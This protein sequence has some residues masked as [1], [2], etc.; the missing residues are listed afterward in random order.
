MRNHAA[1]LCGLMAVLVSISSID[2]GEIG[3]VEDFALAGDRGKALAQLVPGT[4]EYY[5]FHCLH[6]QN[7]GRLQE[8]EK[9]LPAWIK[10]HGHTARVREIKNRQALLQYQ[11]DPQKS[12]DYI[13]RQLGINFNHAKSRLGV[14]PTHPTRLNPAIIDYTTLQSQALS[15]YRENLRGI[16]SEGLYRLYGIRLSPYQLR[17]LL[18]RLQRPDFPGLVKLI[19]RDMG[20]RHSR[21]FGSLPIHRSLTMAQLRKLLRIKGNLRFNQN[22]INTYISRLQP[23]AYVDWQHDAK[24]RAEYLQKLWEFVNRLPATQNS[25]KAHVLYR[26]LVHER[27][28]GVFDQQLFLTYIKLPR[29]LSYVNPK[30][31]RS[32]EMRRHLVR[33]NTD[34]RRLT[35]LPPI[36]NDE[37][38]VRS[39]L[40]HFFLT[41]D[42]ISPYA[43]YIRETYLKRILAETRV[44]A[45]DKDVER[46]VS[47][48]TPRYFKQLKERVDIDFAPT[49]KTY[50][51]AGDPVRIKVDIKNVSKLIVKVYAINT[52]NFYKQSRSGNIDEINLDGLVANQ[53]QVYTYKVPP[54]RRVRRT[55]DFPALKK[56]GLYFVDFIGNGRSNRVVIR[57]G[58]LSFIERM[59]TAGQVLTILN[60]ANQPLPGARAWLAGH[61]YTADAEARVVIPFS[62]KPGTRT[63]VL[64]NDGFACRETFSHKAEKYR[65]QAGIHVDRESLLARKH[66]RVLIR[67][68]LQL[69]DIPV[70]LSVLREISLLISTR[71]HEG[72]V[73]SRKITGFKLYED[74]ESVHEF[75]VPGNLAEISFTLSAKIKPLSK[76]D[77]IDLSVKRTYR[78]NRID[79]TPKTRALHL[80]RSQEGYSLYLLGKTGEPLADRPVQVFMYHRDFR[81]RISAMLQTDAAGRIRLGELAGIR[82]LTAATMDG[83]KQTWW[84][85]R[86]QCSYLSSICGRAGSTLRIPYLGS[87]D[88]VRPGTISLFEMRGGSMAASFYQDRSDAIRIRDGFLEIAGLGAGDYDLLIRETNTRIMIHL[89][90]GEVLD[91]YLLGENHLLEMRTPPPLQITGITSTPK[92]L[93]ISLANASRFTRVHIFATHFVPAFNAFADLGRPRFPGPE[94]I[95]MSKADSTYLAGR[96][97]GDEYRYILE[98]KYAMKFP[99]NMLSRP[100]LL[101]NP[102]A[103]SK[104]T[105]GTD[106]GYDGGRFGGGGRGGG[107]K[108][109]IGRGGGHRRTSMG[110]FANLDFLATRSAVLVNLK[111]DRNGMLKVDAKDLGGHEQVTVVAIDPE[112][113]VC[114]GVFL[115]SDKLPTRDLRLARPLAPGRHFTEQKAITVLT[116]G[117]SLVIDDITTSKL[118][119]YDTLAKVYALYSTLNP[120][121]DLARFTFLTRWSLLGLEEKQKLYSRNACHELNFFVFN[122][123]REFFDKTVKPYLANKKDKTFMDLW[124]L[125]LNLD[126]YLAPWA[127]ARLNITE[128]ILLGKRVEQ[129]RAASQ[130]YVTDRFNLIP[131]D[132]ERFNLLFRTALRGRELEAGDELGLDKARSVN[133]R[134]LRAKDRKSD[135]VTLPRLAEA[136]AP[137]AP[138]RPALAHARR[139]G[140]SSARIRKAKKQSEMNKIMIAEKK[141]EPDDEFYEEEKGLRREAGRFYRKLEKTREW[142]ENNYYHLPIDRQNA[143]LV[144]VNAFW[145]DYANHESGPFV[146]ANFA[147]ASHGFTEMAMALAITDLPFEAKKHEVKYEQARMILRAGSPM[148]VFHQEIK[149]AQPAANRSPILVSQNFFRVDDRYRYEGNE[150]V[151]KFV[152]GEFLAGKVYGCRVVVTNPT[153]SRRKLDTLLQI[154]QG[155]LPVNKGFFTR[156]I[157]MRLEPYATRTLEYYFYF[158]AAG[159]FVQYPVHVARSGAL[160]A[161][162]DPAS[163]TVVDKPSTIDKQAWEYVSQHAD[164]ATVLEYL[165]TRNLGRIKLARIAW[166]MHDKDFF[167]RALTILKKRHA[168]DSTLWSYGILHN[169]RAVIAEYLRHRDEFVS[170]CG[171]WI[172]SPLL[173]IDPVS[174]HAYQHLEYS[175]LVN[176]RAHIFGRR[177]K[178]LNRKFHS[179][180][181]SLMRILA[182]RKVLDDTDRMA[183]TCYLLLQDRVREALDQF[184]M[185]D[186]SR[187]QTRLQYDYLAAYLDFYTGKVDDARR[188]ASRYRDFPVLR[189][190]NRFCEILAQADEIQGKG[191]KVVNPDDRTQSQTALAAREPSLDFRV[192]TGRVLITYANLKHA[193]INYYLMD[194]EQLFSRH[195]F[196]QQ[197]QGRFA[198]VSPNFSQEIDLPGDKSEAGFALPERFR[199][200]NLMIEVAAGPVTRSMACF[201][202]RLN[203]RLSPNYGQL[204]VLHRKTGKPMSRVYIKVYARA[205]GGRVSFYKDGYTDLRGRFDYTSLNTDEID[206]VERLSILI[207]SEND[208]ALIRE[209]LP[210]RQ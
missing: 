72:I 103:I 102:W 33:M 200:A 151:D 49:N 48:M 135:A 12:L 10:R 82:R 99:G 1:M 150:K 162:A 15:R 122:K 31:I 161:N 210:P 90:R 81:D 112:N 14:K 63:L 66:A 19:A 182:C 27:Q 132:I 158:P 128:K 138:A 70:T 119:T 168:Y 3:F 203:V 7:L 154:P 41:S 169:D 95:S 197:H 28:L 24:A 47:L 208:G 54:L 71:D 126:Q 61:E 127:Y 113:T 202:N 74:R 163:F 106:T 104:T 77:K 149:P 94:L 23:S 50:F 92:T 173:S 148:V 8:V 60:E 2:A 20:N 9:L 129:E 181:H 142:A 165:R 125:G 134:R 137:R 124:L 167:T 17:D 86:D 133:R 107:R 175:P 199:S 93:T 160:I 57:K 55:F 176:A 174:R 73:T 157:H 21:G 6:F 180:Y 186:P 177:R 11:Q 16:T 96:N 201:S 159:A 172:R 156:G 80:V 153:N 25:L 22:F 152:T 164:A 34:Y 40:E 62:N 143:D 58:R 130:R 204:R 5:Y 188:I 155:S 84:L 146:S 139:P 198:Y 179:Q 98:R 117:K 59:S 43:P 147:E 189:W 171:P 184:A 141:E 195:P 136:D 101:L 205:R 97:I 116:T 144:R 108:K 38:L 79:A 52:V 39:F 44:L 110:G 68:V 194:I 145:K 36:N 53:E 51:R 76:P 26:Q 13:R 45:G 46:W 185:V 30:Y 78:L 109:F 56:P 35:T 75:S 4:E 100:S 131:P 111:P 114:R 32:R 115:A 121:P 140:A 88:R 178:I 69:N 193:R 83:Q 67:P 196:M 170:R 207:L 190:R 105:T 191:P 91:N 85:N 187:L 87:L 64:I 123:D 206:N 166:R 42:D 183:V 118:E 65:L 18:K 89:A 37:P 209:T 120:D 192:E 29:N